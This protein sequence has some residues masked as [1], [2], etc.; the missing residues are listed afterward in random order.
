LNLILR[1]I[2]LIGC[3]AAVYTFFPARDV[4][5]QSVSV[6]AKVGAPVNDSFTSD[7]T[8]AA[9]STVSIN[10]RYFVGPS[11]EVMFPSNI[12]FEGEALYKRSGYRQ[13][14]TFLRTENKYNIWEFPLMFKATMPR[15]LSF[16]PFGN[17]G[18]AFRRVQGSTVYSEDSSEFKQ[19]LQLADPWSHGFV[20]GGGV[21]MKY[22]SL[23]F[24]PEFRYTRWSNGNGGLP[25]FLSNPNQF[26]YLLGI[27]WGGQ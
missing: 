11:V 12:G 6:G 8:F 18:I 24:E 15:E 17:T 3:V 13:D 19:S 5:A 27:R 23:R 10:R 16:A 20:A 7:T 26:E 25:A 4:S 9:N 14:F 21:S 2:A 1:R 22:A